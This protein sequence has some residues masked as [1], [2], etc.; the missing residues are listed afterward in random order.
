METTRRGA[1]F[2]SAMAASAVVLV[3]LGLPSTAG[4]VADVTVADYQ[5]NEPAGATTLVDSSG[6]GLDGTIGSEIATGATFDGATGHRYSNLAPNG[7]LIPGRVSNVAHDPR[8]N[9]GSGDFAFTIR[10][11]T[12]RSFGNVVQKGQSGAAGGYFKMENPGGEPRCLFRSGDG[13]QRGVTAGRNLS[14]GAWHTVR[15]ERRADSVA[16]YIDGEYAARNDGVVGNIANDWPLS[17]GGKY[18]CNPPNVTC[19]YFVGDIDFLRIETQG[20]ADTTAPATP[21][22]PTATSTRP[23][24]VDLAWPATTD[25]RASTL[26]YRVFRDGSTTPIANVTGGTTGTIRYTD[27]GRTPGAKHT[28]RVRASDGINNSAFSAASGTVTVAGSGS[29]TVRLP[30]GSY[31]KIEVDGRK[32]VVRGRANDPDGRPVYR[33]STTWDG[34]KKYSF[35]RQ[36]TPPTFATSFT[37]Q[38]GD[39]RVCVT[40]LDNPTRQPVS[41]GCKNVTVK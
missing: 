39:H 20:D 15:C 30:S 1:F 11:R 12:T 2:L 28:Y 25:D 18:S 41:L 23:G 13:S 16:M 31:D 14:D 17:V 27:T 22:A 40:L 4:A 33:V 6:N 32:V 26:T 24:E 10:Y 37:A 36:S 3:V 5:M 9:P 34:N 19:D 35:E 7:P 38:P 8:M 21:G 29:N